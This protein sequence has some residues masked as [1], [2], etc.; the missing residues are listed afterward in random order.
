MDNATTTFVIPIVGATKLEQLEQ[1]LQ[2]I[3]VVIPEEDIRHL[4]EISAIDLGFPMKFFKEEAVL[5]NTYGGF[6][7]KIEKRK[8]V[9]H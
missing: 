3:D 2:A 6:Y 9:L 7:D 8:Q 5:M 4:D 1:N